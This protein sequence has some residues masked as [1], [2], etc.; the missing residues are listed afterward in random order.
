MANTQ[1]DLRSSAKPLRL[2]PGILIVLVQ[3]IARFGIPVVLPDF[4]AYG[5]MVGI[6]GGL[7]LL[8]WWLFFSRAAWVDRFGG[9]VLMIGAMAATWPLLDGS[10]ATGA[11]GAMFFILAIPGLCLAFVVAAAATRHMQAPVRRATMVAAIVLACGVW[12]LVRT[13]GFTGSFDNDLAWRWTPTAEQRLL[14]RGEAFDAAQSRPVDAA[15]GGSPVTVPP[16]AAPASSP[17]DTAKVAD[18]E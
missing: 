14:D 2:W 3:W 18:V 15:G 5:V 10:I 8:V 13:G 16:P 1:G 4:T 11:M 12:T 17:D 7:A 6:A 9:I